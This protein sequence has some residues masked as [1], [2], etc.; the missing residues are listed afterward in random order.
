MSGAQALTMVGGWGAVMSGCCQAVGPE[1]NAA[2]AQGCLT[3]HLRP[4]RAAL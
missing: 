3:A 1:N 2:A 4:P